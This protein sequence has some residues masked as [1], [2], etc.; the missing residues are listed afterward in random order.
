MKGFG[1]WTFRI[2]TMLLVVFLIDFNC[3]NM[4][5]SP[6]KSHH[7]IVTNLVLGGLLI[8]L[9]ISQLNKKRL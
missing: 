5:P 1:T 9:L 8:L 2:I 3:D 4:R 6:E 7:I